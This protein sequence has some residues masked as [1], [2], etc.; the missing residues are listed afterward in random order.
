MNKKITL[1]A[2]ALKCGSLGAI[3]LMKRVAACRTVEEN[4]QPTTNRSGQP[5]KS[6]PGFP[7]EI[8]DGYNGKIVGRSWSAFSVSPFG[9]A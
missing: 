5:C 1:L 6:A 7:K 9:D 4:R 8:R 2:L 3:G